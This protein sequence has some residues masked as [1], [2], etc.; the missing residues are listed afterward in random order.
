MGSVLAVDW[1]VTFLVVEHLVAADCWL[2][3]GVAGGL[4]GVTFVC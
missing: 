4:D 3:K 2:T 1:L